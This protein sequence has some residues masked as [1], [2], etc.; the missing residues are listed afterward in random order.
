VAINSD[1]HSRASRGRFFPQKFSEVLSLVT[2]SGFGFHDYY[3]RLPIR[4]HNCEVECDLGHQLC[5][6]LPKHYLAVFS[7]PDTVPVAL[8]AASLSYAL[9]EFATLDNAP[10][11]SVRQ[12]QFV[13]YRAYL[14]PLAHVTIAQHI[15]S[16][17]QGSLHFKEAAMLS[18]A[19]RSPP[20]QTILAQR[21]VA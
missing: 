4:F 14:G 19:Q 13:I 8:A 5:S 10:R 12:E 2:A 1:L 7:L 20:Q 3:K 21:A 15:V 16:G 6:F 18:K 9:S 11:V 17:N